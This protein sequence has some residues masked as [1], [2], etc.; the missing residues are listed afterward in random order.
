MNLILGADTFNPVVTDTGWSEVTHPLR[1]IRWGWLPPLQVGKQQKSTLKGKG[2]G[3]VLRETPFQ[4]NKA[5]VKTKVLH[6]LKLL[7]KNTAFKNTLRK[8]VQISRCFHV[9][10]CG[11]SPLGL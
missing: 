8:R 10:G 2:I 3:K 6:M 7:D 4:E 1:E 11:V 9:M 5:S